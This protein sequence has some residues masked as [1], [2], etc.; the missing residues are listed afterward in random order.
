[1]SRDGQGDRRGADHWTEIYRRLPD[2]VYETEAPV[3]D[4]PELTR[5]ELELVEWVAG[6]LGTKLTSPIVDIAC[7]PGRHSNLLARRGHSVVGFDHS[8]GLLRI[9]ANGHRGDSEGRPALVCA[10]LR[11]PPFESSAFGS[12]LLLGKSFGYFSERR[13]LELLRDVCAMLA[14]GG[15]FCLELPDREPYLASMQPVETEERVRANGE[16]LRSVFRCRWSDASRRLLV[17]ESHLLPERDEVFWEGEWDVRLYGAEE[18]ERLLL[19]VGF[20]EVLVVPTRLVEAQG[21]KS[22]VLI[23]GAIKARR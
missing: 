11:Q 14:P 8:A 4:N 10:D 19:A 3:F 17:R 13:N 22:D 15:F 5:Q 12:A 2:R 16:R 6:K 9:A 7:G 1:M 18:I 21:A 23:A 20:A